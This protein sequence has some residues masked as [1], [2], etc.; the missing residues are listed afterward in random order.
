MAND[1]SLVPRGSGGPAHRSAGLP[2]RVGTDAPIHQPGAMVW[3]GSVRTREECWDL[4][5]PAVRS[6]V[7]ER[8]GRLLDW[9]ATD[10][11]G[12]VSVVVFGTRALVAV[13]PTVNAAGRPASELVTIGLDESSFRS[14]AVREGATGTVPGVL[15]R[16]GAGQRPGNGPGSS[17]GP[18]GIDRLD[19]GL[20]GFLG[21]LPARAQQLLQD[22]FLT[23]TEPLVGEDFAYRTGSTRSLGGATIQVWCYLTDHRSLTF[24]AGIGHGFRDRTGARSWELT[25]WRAQTAPRQSGLR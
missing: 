11:D 15:R 13:R 1:N 14:V 17:S 9:W 2:A 21:M 6:R 7:D 20:R 19:E 3:S 25:C 8:I 18:P 22:P 4:L 16:A 24:C 23:R 12:R 5:G 10:S